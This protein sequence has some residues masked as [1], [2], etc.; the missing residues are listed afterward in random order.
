[1][2]SLKHQLPDSF[3]DEELRS[4]YLVS[5]KQKEIWAV[6]LDLLTELIA[7]CDR[8]HLQYFASG[9]TALGTVRHGGYIPWDD[10]IDI[11]MLRP[12]YNKF[13]EIA[14]KEFK[15][16]YFFQT[17]QSDPGSMRGHAQLRNS[18][19]TG[20]LSSER[21]KRY[22][23][24]QGIFIDIFPLDYVPDDKEERKRF[25]RNTL[26]LKKLAFYYS[27]ISCRYNENSSNNTFFKKL[28]HLLFGWNK[29]NL[30]YACYEKYMQKYAAKPTG[31]VGYLCLDLTDDSLLL[32]EAW[33]H[34]A[35]YMPF[36]MLS[37]PVP[38]E[39][40]AALSRRYGDWRT[41]KQAASFHNGVV[42]DTQA[43]YTDYLLR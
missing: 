17:E 6:E 34:K 11:V 19:T 25:I 12:E 36:E 42:F 16:P 43:P 27:A 1:M 40:N 38:E 8:N 21:N 18:L 24:N 10:D 37:L 13:S 41:P 14:R 4:G 23:F 9:G 31:R 32:K 15:S 30:M 7:V 2:V 39:Y 33:Y 35:V 22:S 28:L 26:F 29:R 3:F 20:I 5:R